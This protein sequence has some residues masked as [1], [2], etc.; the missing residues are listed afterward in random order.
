MGA[1]TFFLLAAAAAASP[2]G[3]TIRAA[4]EG[5][6]TLR[7]LTPALIGA[8]LPAPRPDMV[9]RETMIALP[10]G[11]SAPIRLYEFE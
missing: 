8:G 7:I 11:S 5:R 9:A 10:D 3:S 4:A 1:S 6:V 2:T